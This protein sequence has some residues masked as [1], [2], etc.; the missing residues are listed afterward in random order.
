M[1]NGTKSLLDLSRA[2]QALA[3]VGENVKFTKKKKKKVKDITG[4]GVKNI[5]GISLI[6][7]QKDIAKSL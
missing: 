5:V 1:T 6:K 4:L 2:A 3:L 7:V